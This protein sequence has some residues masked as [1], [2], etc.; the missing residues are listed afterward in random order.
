M[1]PDLY[2]MSNKRTKRELILFWNK[3][4]V[5]PGWENIE[6]NCYT[7]K[8]KLPYDNH[9]TYRVNINLEEMKP[10]VLEFVQST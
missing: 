1:S 9:D 6:F 4:N 7:W 5:L 2:I 3:N 8:M 10:S